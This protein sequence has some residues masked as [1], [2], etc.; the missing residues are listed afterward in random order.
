MFT[1]PLALALLATAALGCSPSR[2]DSATTPSRYLFVWAGPYGH[3]SMAGN[4]RRSS[5]TSDFLAV[6]DADPASSGYGKRLP[7]GTSEMPARWRI[8][9]N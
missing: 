2:T 8:T 1:P 4:M 3:D 9:P 5:G 6:L 7:R